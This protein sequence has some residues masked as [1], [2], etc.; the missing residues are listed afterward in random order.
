MA[1]LSK[2]T[3]TFLSAFLFLSSIATLTAQDK[4]RYFVYL[5]DKQGIAYTLDKPEK[6]LTQRAIDR[7]KRQGIAFAQ[8][9]LPVNMTYVESIKAQGGR[10]WYASRWFNAVLVEATEADLAKIKALPFVKPQIDLLSP[11]R[12]ATF[13]NKSPL[14]DATFKDKAG[15][16]KHTFLAIDSAKNYGKAYNQ[17][18]MLEI[19]TMHKQ[20]YRGQGMVIAVLDAGFENGDKVP[21]LT[22]LH[23][24][25]RILGTYN[26]V[27]GQENVYNT[28][29]H[30]LEVLS[31][32][33]SYLLNKHIGTAPEASYYLFR[34]EDADTE[35]KV[36]E[37]NW[38]VAAEKADSLGADLINSSLG[39]TDFSDDSD[40]T[41]K[42]MNGK[43]SIASRA[44]TLAASVGIIVVNSVGNEGGGDWKYMGAPA[45]AD[46]IISVGSVDGS[47]QRSYFSSYGPTYDKR[48]K[49]N[50]SA[51]GGSSSVGKI[52]GNIGHNDGTSFSSPILCGMVASFWQAFPQLTNMEVIEILQQSASQASKPDTILGY[53]IPNLKLAYTIAQLK[54][55]NAKTG[56][57]IFPNPLPDGQAIR[58]AF[59]EYYQGKKV[60]IEILSMKGN[61]L[62]TAHV[63]KAGKQYEWNTTAKFP[64]GLYAIRVIEGKHAETRR[65]LKE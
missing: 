26:F 54:I 8:K 15:K 65:W 34:T 39:Y 6:F 3:L 13:S 25:G 14:T 12:S 36:E 42:D 1:N 33:G 52:N 49:P 37:V 27:E 46:S 56:F 57:H 60:K 64:K 21:F 55:A 30:G 11:I 63:N 35:Y 61:L 4:K 43:V 22:H 23:E 59:S 32:M 48:L 29:N 9:D 62:E 53:G 24:D 44:A 31:C 18:K 16:E 17:A 40:Y 47:K 45:D 50:L 10:V 5:K 38:L 58:I 41:Y 51:Q 19:P 7:R 2:T 28:G 20:G